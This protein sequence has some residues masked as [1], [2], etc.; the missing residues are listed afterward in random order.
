M[1]GR[2]DSRE[3]DSISGKQTSKAPRSQEEETG[4]FGND[5]V[6]GKHKEWNESII[7]LA[8]CSHRRGWEWGWGQQTTTDNDKVQQR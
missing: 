1:E 4:K 2:V 3:G 7:G 6:S 5:W 8:Q